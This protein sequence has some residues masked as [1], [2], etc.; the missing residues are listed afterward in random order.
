MQKN[1]RGWFTGDLYRF[2]DLMQ[3]SGLA[4]QWDDLPLDYRIGL[5]AKV[6]ADDT[7]GAWEQFMSEDGRNG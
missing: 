5:A 4:A 3:R 2:Y 6:A 1:R 7:M